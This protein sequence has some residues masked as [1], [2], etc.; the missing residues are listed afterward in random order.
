MVR[1]RHPSATDNP[2]WAKN[3]TLK[4]KT[5]AFDR[6]VYMYIIT[7]WAI[8]PVFENVYWIF[9]TDLAITTVLITIDFSLKVKLYKESKS[10]FIETLKVSLPETMFSLII[11]LAGLIVHYLMASTIETLIWL[12]LFGFSVVEIA[13]IDKIRAKSCKHDG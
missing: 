2:P 12:F 6:Y 10:E 11:T 4:E 3:M 8:F 1:Q 5:K 9:Y 13:T 7:M